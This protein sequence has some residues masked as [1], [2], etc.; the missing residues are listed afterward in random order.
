MRF[1]VRNL[2]W[3][4]Q[5]GRQVS[6]SGGEH[7]KWRLGLLLHELSGTPLSARSETAQRSPVCFEKGFNKASSGGLWLGTF[8]DMCGAHVDNCGFSGSI[9]SGFVSALLL[10]RKAFAPKA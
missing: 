7:F 5:G 8:R 4:T 9:P 1:R 10:S 6:D 3:E 2:N